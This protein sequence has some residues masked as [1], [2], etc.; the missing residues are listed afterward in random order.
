[1]KFK[2]QVSLRTKGEVPIIELSG[3]FDDS[4][5]E[6]FT[7]TYEKACKLNPQDI[8]IKFDSESQIY[9]SGIA[10]L[11]GLVSSAENKGQKIHVTGLSEHF[12]EVFRLTG[13]TKYIQI[14]L[15]EQEALA[16]LG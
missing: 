14:F 2:K 4:I 3:D 8:I 5:E 12:A 9:S 11:V 7:A 10:V 6:V 15:S 1:V 16:R 13:L